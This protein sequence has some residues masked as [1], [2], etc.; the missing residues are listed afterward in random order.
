M[1]EKPVVA[2]RS[3]SPS[4]T[5]RLFFAPGWPGSSEAGFSC[6]AS[7]MRSFLSRHVVTRS[8]PSALHDSDC[9]M[10]LCLSVNFAA[11]ASTSQIFTVW[12]PEELAKIFSAAVLKSTC[13]TFLHSCE[14]FAPSFSGREYKPHVPRQTGNRG[15]VSRLLRICIETEP[16]WDFPDE[17]LYS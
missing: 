9:T 2:I 13:P 5:A 17:N 14:R 10:S 11:P 7:Q 3:C 4:Q 6:L 15:N 16:F 1:R 12:S 8:D